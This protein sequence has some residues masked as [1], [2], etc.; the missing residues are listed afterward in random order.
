MKKYLLL[1]L[2]ALL[3]SFAA[4]AQEAYAVYLRGT[5]TFYYDNQKS[6]KQGTVYELNSTLEPPA[7]REIN[8]N[9]TK[10]VFHSSFTDARPVSTFAWFVVN[11]STIHLR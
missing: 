5:L 8:P 1:T 11:W 9:V 10:V 6:N 3:N 2:F 7:W 4:I